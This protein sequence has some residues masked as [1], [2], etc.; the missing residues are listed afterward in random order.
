M[1]GR[2][3]KNKEQSLSK[4]TTQMEMSGKVNMYTKFNGE[5]KKS[6]SL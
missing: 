5:R 3:A 1:A 4:S 6:D 2:K